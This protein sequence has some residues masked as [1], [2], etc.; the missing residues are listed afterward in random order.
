M[1]VIFVQVLAQ[2]VA[3]G[4]DLDELQLESIYHVM[5]RATI[6]LPPT[7]TLPNVEARGDPKDVSEH[8]NA[9]A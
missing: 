7:A 2:I 9:P 1:I 5:M 4:A 8:W 3:I 6:E